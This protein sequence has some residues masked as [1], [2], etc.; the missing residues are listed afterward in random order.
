MVSCGVLVMLVCWFCWCSLALCLRIVAGL[1]LLC[2]VCGVILVGL[3]CFCYFMVVFG[4]LICFGVVTCCS[5]CC[6]CWFV[7]VGV[8]GGWF[9]L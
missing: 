6:V 5:V 8:T 3:F 7:C 2:C 4:G 1:Y 9:C